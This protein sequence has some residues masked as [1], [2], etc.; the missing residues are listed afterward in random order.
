[1]PPKI[2]IVF[3][4]MLSAWNRLSQPTIVSRSVEG[5]CLLYHVLIY[6]TCQYFKPFTVV[7]YN[8]RGSSTTS[9][10]IRQLVDRGQYLVVVQPLT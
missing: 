3:P 7:V 5:Y 2:I 8:I 1:M 10:I 9:D 4:R 6:E